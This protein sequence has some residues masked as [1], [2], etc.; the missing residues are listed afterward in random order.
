MSMPDRT[1][2][3]WNLSILAVVWAVYLSGVDIQMG[4]PGAGKGAATGGTMT[5]I[6]I[7]ATRLWF[8]PSR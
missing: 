4:Y 7:F 5:A 1:I 2:V 6:I 3:L 8:R